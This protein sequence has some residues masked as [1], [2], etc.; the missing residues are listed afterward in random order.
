MSG[1]TGRWVETFWAAVEE[2]APPH[3]GEHMNKNK[4]VLILQESAQSIYRPLQSTYCLLIVTWPKL[5]EGSNR[6]DATWMT[7]LHFKQ[8]MITVQS[9]ARGSAHRHV[10]V[11]NSVRRWVIFPNAFS[12]AAH[13]PTPRAQPV[14][15]EWHYTHHSKH[16]TKSW[17]MEKCIRLVQC[18]LLPLYRHSYCPWF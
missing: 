2:L 14:L 13:L 16:H 18:V 6:A 12:L 4:S 15:A 1:S 5:T 9:S 8:Y 11:K 17:P 10:E 7:E 3:P